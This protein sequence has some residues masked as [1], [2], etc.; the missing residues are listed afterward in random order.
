MPQ[1]AERDEKE[2]LAQRWHVV[3]LAAT[4]LGDRWH[5]ARAAAKKGAAVAPAQRAAVDRRFLACSP[6]LRLIRQL[7]DRSA[8]HQRAWRACG[9]IE[10]VSM[11]LREALAPPPVRSLVVSLAGAMHTHDPE[12]WAVAV[13]EEVPD[14]LF[15]VRS[16][17]PVVEVSPAALPL[18]GPS[19]LSPRSLP[20]STPAHSYV[21]RR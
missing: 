12:S 11:A 21:V 8:Q 19:L 14:A 9:G 6:F 18:I 5:A 20:S 7:V 10:F 17:C 3:A 13:R 16:R 4:A 15:E 1:G 2:A